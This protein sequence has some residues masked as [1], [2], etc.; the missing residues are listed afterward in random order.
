MVQLRLADSS[1]RPLV[2]NAARGGALLGGAGTT[3]QTEISA[4]RLTSKGQLVVTRGRDTVRAFVGPVAV[5]DTSVPT[6]V[7]VVATSAEGIAA[8]SEKTV[9]ARPVPGGTYRWFLLPGTILRATG[10]SGGMMRVQFDSALEAWVDADDVQ[11]LPAGA[12]APVRVTSN[13]RVVN[14][15]GSVDLIIPTGERP[16]YFVESQGDRLV[17][18]LYGTTGNS[19]IIGQRGGTDDLLESVTLEPVATDRV[20]YVLQLKRPVYGW[21]VLWGNGGF[22]LRV[23]RAPVVRL[24]APLAG[25]TIAVDAGHPPIGST[26]PTGLYEPVPTLAISERLKALLEARGATV[27]MTRTDAAPVALGARPIMARRSN[28]HAFVS[29]H[30]NALPDGTNPFN[31]RFGSG[32]YWFYGPSAPL[33]QMVQRAL[34]AQLGLPDEGT[35]FDNLAVARNSWMPSILC[36]GAYIMF[37]DH[38]AALRTP[39]FQEAYARGIANG[40]EAYFRAMAVGQQR[41]PE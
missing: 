27:Y 26:G 18:T 30:L 39:E 8:D 38:E 24:E 20:R 23:R 7:M 16:A 35:F 31:P 15:G 34:V 9:V 33:A 14:S 28:A 1:V 22:T 37:P 6:F 3:W 5:A 13:A 10:R 41:M 32:T 29:V 25:L 11:A 17:L 21:Q 36:E 40:L 2:S 19:D 12:V 4:S